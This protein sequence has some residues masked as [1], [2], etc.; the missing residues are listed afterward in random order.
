MAVPTVTTTPIDARAG[1]LGPVFQKA[2]TVGAGD[3]DTD[4][5]LYTP[6]D[7]EHVYVCGMLITTATGAS[8]T[9]SSD[10]TA[11]PVIQLDAMGQ[12]IEPFQDAVLMASAK[13]EPLKVKASAACSFVVFIVVGQSFVI[14]V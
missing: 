5:T 14:G 10:A 3:V 6:A 4:V 2:V 1:L 7:N 11:L 12:I 8:I 9:F 13:G